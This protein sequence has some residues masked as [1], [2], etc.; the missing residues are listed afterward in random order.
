MII[1]KKLKSNFYCFFIFFFVFVRLCLSQ[2]KVGDWNSLTSFLQIRDVEFIENTLYTATEGGIL[3]IKEND[4]SVITNTNGLI[5]VDLL[6]IAKDNNDN[7]WIGGNSPFGFLQLYDPLNKEP[8]SSFD[9]QLTAIHDIQVKGSITWILFQDGQ[10][11]GLMK[12]VFDDRWEYRDSYRNYPEEISKINCFIALDSMI[13]LGTNDGIYSSMLEN[14]L[15]N[16]FSW[17]KSIQDIEEPISSID[18]N[19]DGLVFTTDNGLFEYS[20]LSNQLNQIETQIELE[21]AQNIFVYGNDYW[22]SEGKHLYLFRNNELTLIE[23]KYNIL[24]I[25]KVGDKYTLGTDNGIIFLEWKSSTELFEKSLFIPNSPVTNSFSAIEVLEDGRLVGGSNQG[26]SIFS[27]AGWRNILEI[28]EINTEI[29]NESYN[30]DQ[31]I[32]DTVEYDFGEFISDIE[33]GPDGLVYCAI[34]GSRVYN[35][36][37]SRWSGGI[38]VVD[39][40]NPENISTIDTSYLS[41]YT[42]SNSDLP[43]QVVLDVEFDNNGN[44]WVANPFCTNGNSPIHVRS[45][46]GIWKHFGSNETETSLSYTPIS[47]AFDNNNRIWVSSFQA[48]DINIG[49]PNGGIAVLSFNG[50]PFNP[51]SF[52]WNQINLNGTVWSLGIGNN[53]RLYYLTPSGLNYYDLKPG[54]NPVLSENLYPYFPNISFGSGSKINIDFQGNIWASSS[55]QGVYVLQ[56]NTSYWPNLEGFNRLNSDLLSGEI[57]DI[58]FDHK[59]NLAYIATS[60]GVSVLKIPFGTPKNDFKNLKIFPSPYYVPSNNPMIIDGIIYESSFKVMTLN[61]R[62]IRDITSGGVSKDGQQLKWD[63]RDSEGNYVSTGVYLLMIYHQDGKNTI[64]KITVINKS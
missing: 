34:R 44:L 16:P 35:S 20:Y 27:N 45:P 43:Y 23:N 15:K 30:Y 56:E 3:S 9:F 11:N 26:L 6:S 39:I 61:G 36:N 52:F 59:R 48:A 5:G 17:T 25:S 14:N 58:D 33:Q 51:N 53:D 41:Y 7:L 50:D 38:I 22:F 62:V 4:Y 60:N 18:S 49:R 31:F 57:R 64:E 13:F 63:G 37:P 40:D 28:K 21:Q 32:A 10:D 8:I 54:S 12:F 46:N 2:V 1:Y 24:T 29:I 42:S 55:S 47:I 19:A